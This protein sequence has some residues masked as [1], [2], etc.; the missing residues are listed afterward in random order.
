[1]HGQ[2][3]DLIASFLAR[4]VESGTG[5]AQIADAIGATCID[6]D[7]ALAPVIGQRGV[8]AL[9]QRSLHQTGRVRG[10]LAA[11]H[12]PSVMD[13]EALKS[14]LARQTSADAAAGGL[15][16]VKTFHEL[17]TGLIGVA[18]TERLLRPVWITY[19]SGSLA[20]QDK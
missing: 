14:A 2:P 7:A 19:L 15:L 11:T 20:A 10:W 18:L 5:A 3:T 9:Y 13:I 4:A 17:L 6:L 1:M 8:A 12:D 16:L